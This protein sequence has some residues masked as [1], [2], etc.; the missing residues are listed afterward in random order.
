MSTTT[1]D[2][3]HPNYMDFGCYAINMA[4]AAK[5][6]CDVTIHDYEAKAIRQAV[7]QEVADRNIHY[8]TRFESS[9]GHDELSLV[10]P[11]SYVI[12]GWQA[13]QMMDTLSL[14]WHDSRLHHAAHHIIK[15]ALTGVA[16]EGR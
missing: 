11:G 4:D 12:D 9:A 13:F 8:H 5:F 7:R 15:N 14:V 6:T 3:I 1:T 16:T 10:I 2:A